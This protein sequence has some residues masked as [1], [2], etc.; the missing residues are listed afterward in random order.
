MIAFL[1]SS[2]SF[3]LPTQHLLQQVLNLQCIFFAYFAMIASF[4]SVYFAMCELLLSES[5]QGL[6]YLSENFVMQI[7]YLI[8][9]IISET[10]NSLLY[11]S[12]QFTLQG[13]QAPEGRKGTLLE[14][15]SGA[16][17]LC[18]EDSHVSSQK[19]SSVKMNRIDVMFLQWAHTGKRYVHVSSCNSL[20]KCFG[21]TRQTVS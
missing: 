2:Y 19:F 9:T 18:L 4:A 11:T 20:G 16:Q 6:K 1:F 17:N 8:F 7:H 5:I 21:L 15:G 10:C 3:S 12:W 14:C 13:I